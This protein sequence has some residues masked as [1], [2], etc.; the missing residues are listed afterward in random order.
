MKEL[1]RRRL[2]ITMCG[3]D[4]T[5]KQKYQAFEI[6]DKL[7]RVNESDIETIIRLTE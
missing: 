6:F 7:E 1:A 2:F 3:M 5:N 4:Y